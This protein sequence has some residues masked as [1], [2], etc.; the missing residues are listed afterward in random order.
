[1]NTSLPR[2]KSTYLFRVIALVA[3]LLS[4]GSAVEAQTTFPEWRSVSP[5]SAPLSGHR[6][7]LLPTGEILVSGGVNAGGSVTRT[8]LLYSHATRSFRPTINQLNTGRSHHLLLSVESTGGT[9]VYAVGG[10]SGGGGSFRGESSIE[11][12]SYDAA[13]D[14][15]RWRPA[16]RLP[17]GAGDLAGAWDKGDY[18]VVTGGYENSGGALRSG[19]RSRMAVRINVQNDQVETLPDMTDGRAEQ[20]VA[21]I[22][23]ENG[24]LA[25][26][27]AGGEANVAAT[28][29]QILEGTLW[30]SL[31]NPP[32]IYRSGGVG[33]GDRADI[34]RAFGGFDD[35]GLPTDA[36]G[37]YDVK[38]GWR[39]APRLT[40]ARARFDM[41]LIA[42]NSDSV[43]AYLA[44]AGS[45]VAGEL[46]S[47]EI[48]QMPNSS[49]PNGIWTPLLP[50]VDPASEREVAINGA[51]LPV[52]LGG[53]RGGSP[54]NGVEVLQ[55]LRASDLVFPDE[56]VGR[57]S[58]SIQLSI[59]NEWLLPVR[60][61]T[62]RV[63]GA[64]FFYR[65]D[66]ADFVIPAGGSRTIRLYFQPGA[67][68]P[69]NGELLFDVGELTNRVKLSGNA[70][71]STL[72]VINAPY[73]GG[74]VFLK[75][76]KT[77]CFHVLRNDG[78]DTAV[79]DSVSI[80]PPGTFRV[81]SPKGRS[82]IPPGDSLE[83]CVEF[84]PDSRGL[85]AAA[86]RVHLAGRTFPGE[87]IAR[88]VRRFLTATVVSEECDTV[89]YQPGLEISGFVRL[90]N[91]GDSVVSVTNATIT[92]SALGLFRLA[93]PTIYTITLLPGE[94][95]LIEV[96]FAP[97][98]E[99][100]E[101]ATITFENDGDT[102]AAV[103]LCFVARSRFLAPS[104]SSVDF[105][106]VCVGDSVET[107]LLLENPGGFDLVEL[108]SATIDPT[109]ELRLT[110]F[111]PV[112]LGPREFTRVQVHY[113]PT[114]PGPLNGLLRVANSQGDLEVPI[115]GTGLSAAQFSPAGSSLAVGETLPLTV[116][117][118]GLTGPLPLQ[119]TT[120]DL[121][122]DPS[123]L[124]PLGI[125]SVAG[126]PVVDENASS[127][128]IV[129]GGKA[130]IEVVWQG[131][132]PAGDGPAFA[133]EI[134][135]LRG[136]AEKSVLTLEDGG[137]NG[138]CL[139][140]G[141]SE[142]LLL[143]A[144]WG[145]AGGIRSAAAR[146]L[147]VAPQPASE[148]A[149]VIALNQPAGDLQVDLVNTRGE[150][151]RS[152]ISSSPDEGSRHLGLDLEG[153]PSGLYLVRC[154]ALEGRDEGVSTVIVKQ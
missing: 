103:D 43:S 137:G 4:R 6:A 11:V 113:V 1:M 69:H 88:G 86:V 9:K 8:S 95:R 49:L 46:N 81:I 150:V 90:D 75:D 145:P 100:R 32:L 14:N 48:F 101:T 39:N 84:E 22:L 25:T 19:A 143:P 26:L 40:E 148:R 17:V 72:A 94:S 154:L 93:D 83:V 56:E 98:R 123:M 18:L 67:P 99:S 79:I 61:H 20:T 131:A 82:A 117:L 118:T 78:T 85:F 77:Y 133:I 132:G 120:L 45:G 28:A 66:T 7:L 152:A 37:W 31:A 27:V 3:L 53:L 51:N 24:N 129:G 142:L 12:L 106:E 108:L 119:T 121:S 96:I 50:L 55:P 70:V 89:T 52:V 35:A 57:R 130:R 73:D 76:R 13:A 116:D 109:P 139:A 10:Y 104:Q 29:T 140:K 63:S 80:D 151:V 16:G 122:Y 107:T 135:G 58:D 102:A 74:E 21:T 110:G 97:V 149:T 136:E 127:I 114:T 112:L 147:F 33:F 23:D 138:V 68:G 60:L 115:T 34:A 125:R 15:W 87:T 111:T 128:V 41:T 64:A 54:V 5:L 36:S 59:R 126:G 153:L 124:Y 65:G 62:F 141:S 91:P 71:A 42:G 146:G 38:R 47:T 30:N 92:Q 105:G 44:V 144:C 134:E 2:S